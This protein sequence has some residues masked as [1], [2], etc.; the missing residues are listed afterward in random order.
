MLADFLIDGDQFRAQFPQTMILVDFRLRLAPGSRGRKRFGDG[1][2]VH[3]SSEPNLGIMSPIFRL[4]AM[5]CWLSAAASNRADRACAQIAE[6]AE[7]VKDL[8]SLG[9]Q[10]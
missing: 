4:G 8:G 3:S 1:L 5:T 9:F 6:S 2:A 10:L 7:L